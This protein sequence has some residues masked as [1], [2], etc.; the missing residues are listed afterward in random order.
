MPLSNSVRFISKTT[1]MLQLFI[2]TKF[3]LLATFDF[4]NSTGTRDFTHFQRRISSVDY[5]IYQI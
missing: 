2:K 4:H 3:L 1:Q 5:R